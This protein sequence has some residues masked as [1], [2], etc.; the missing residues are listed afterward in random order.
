MFYFELLKILL[1][2]FKY[3]L[4]LHNI[5]LKNNNWTDFY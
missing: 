1:L 4:I 2:I 5:Q 3:P